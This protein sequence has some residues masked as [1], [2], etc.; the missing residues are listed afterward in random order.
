MRFLKA[1]FFTKTPTGWKGFFPLLSLPNELILLIASNLTYKDLS[2]LLLTNHHL[3]WL[4][5]SPLYDLAAKIQLP[6]FLYP[7]DRHID[8][9][10]CYGTI[11][12]VLHYMVHKENEN[13]VRLLLEKGADITAQ[14]PI[15][16]TALH[17]AAGEGYDGI[18]RLVM[19]QPAAGNAF[20]IT[21][22]CGNTPLH[23]AAQKGILSSVG[24][25]LEKGFDLNIRNEQGATPLHFAAQSAHEA[26]V[27]LLLESGAEADARASGSLRGDLGTPLQWLANMSCFLVLG[28]N[29]NPEPTFKALIT[30]GA[31]VNATDTGGRTV[32]HSTCIS[33]TTDY[34]GLKCPKRIRTLLKASHKAVCITLLE[35]GAN[36]NARDNDGKTALHHAASHLEGYM[37]RNLLEL[38]AGANERDNDGGTALFYLLD[39]YYCA[40]TMKMVMLLLGYGADATIGTADGRMPLEKVEKG[41]GGKE[42]TKLIQKFVTGPRAPSK[43][44]ISRLIH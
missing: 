4:L 32:L 2:R 34:R 13:M 6:D 5:K 41:V 16:I 15:G 11:S 18:V 35:N 1:G 30:G 24:A 33:G 43:S 40:R 29:R 8:Y 25:L 17:I 10:S 21:N 31:D 23:C 9:I 22:N 27:R 42:V 38:G 36:I 28:H 20:Q 7:Q 37:V 12:T 3:A 14:N 44:F 39:Y 19:G 26:V